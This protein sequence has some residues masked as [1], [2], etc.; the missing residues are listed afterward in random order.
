MSF[1]RYGIYQRAQI[2]LAY[3]LSMKQLWDGLTTA[4][5]AVNEQR[6]ADASCEIR[7]LMKGVVDI[8]NREV[9]PVIKMCALFINTEDED[10]RTLSDAQIQQKQEDWTKEGYDIFSFF[11][12]ALRLV[13]D[14]IQVYTSASQDTSKTRSA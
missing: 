13:P 10:R 2:E 8:G 14:L 11:Q 12:L 4:Y 1:G 3:D 5:D 9:H 6:F 7:D